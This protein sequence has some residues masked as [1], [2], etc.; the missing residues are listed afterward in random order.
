MA[1]DVE[2]EILHRIE[3]DPSANTQKIDREVRVSNFNECLTSDG[4]LN[5][6]HQEDT[7]THVIHQNNLQHRF[8]STFEPVLLA[9]IL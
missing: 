3:E 2:E 6:H 1:G 7:N 8:G 9:D 4:I 5:T